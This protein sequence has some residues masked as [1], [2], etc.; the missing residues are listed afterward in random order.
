MVY[1][2]L[3]KAKKYCLKALGALFWT[4][5]W[6]P[7]PY[8]TSSHPTSGGFTTG[9]GIGVGP[10]QEVLGITRGYT[11]VGKVLSLRKRTTRPGQ[12]PGDWREYGV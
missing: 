12:D 2:S 1:E 4:W 8:V 5:I 11:R 3:K 6:E 7:I 9:S 10:I